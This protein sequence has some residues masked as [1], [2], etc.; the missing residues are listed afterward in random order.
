MVIEYHGKISG[1]GRR[2][3]W[4]ATAFWHYTRWQNQLHLFLLFSLLL[5]QFLLRTAVDGV[6]E[7]ARRGPPSSQM[8]ADACMRCK[9]LFNAIISPSGGLWMRSSQNIDHH[10]IDQHISSPSLSLSLFKPFSAKHCPISCTLFCANLLQHFCTFC[11]QIS[12]AVKKINPSAL[13]LSICV[14]LCAQVSSA[15]WRHVLPAWC[16]H[17]KRL[18]VKLEAECRQWR[19][20]YNEGD[21]ETL[22]REEA[23][24]SLWAG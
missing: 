20:N 17:D 23:P 15:W 19:E 7:T 22:K 6:P 18:W 14:R 16:R 12:K 9:L 1:C 4:G 13:L 8:N 21:K 24:L 11:P 10:R 2:G 5:S 3:H